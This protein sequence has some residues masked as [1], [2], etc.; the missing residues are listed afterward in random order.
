MDQFEAARVGDHQQLRHILTAHNVN[1][2]G[3]WSYTALHKA[4]SYEQVECVKV[5][6]EMGAN[7]NARNNGQQTPLHCAVRGGVEIARM[8]LDAGAIV[9]AKD[10]SGYTPLYSAILHNHIDIARLLIDRGGEVSNVTL[11]GSLTA[12]PDW[13]TNYVASRSNCRIVSIVIIGIHKYHRTN[14]TGNN[15]INVLK[16]IAKH[17]WSSRMDDGWRAPHIEAKKPR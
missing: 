7:V 10:C 12:I 17:I 5:C 9:D 6:I 3:V 15:D 1:D 2:A 14:V 13:V 4:A 11:N 8:L 16:L